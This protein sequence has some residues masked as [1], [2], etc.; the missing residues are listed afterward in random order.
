M[1]KE[2]FQKPEEA[3]HPTEALTSRAMNEGEHENPP[4]CPG[5]ALCQAPS[6]PDNSALGQARSV[7]C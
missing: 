3:L 4:S 7:V 1:T 6:F 5:A 2:K